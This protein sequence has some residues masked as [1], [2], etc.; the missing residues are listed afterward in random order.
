MRIKRYV[1]NNMQNAIAM[2]KAD[3][4][5]EAVILHTKRFKRGGIFGLF[6]RPKVEVLAAIEPGT[7]PST[8][9]ERELRRAQET[10]AAALDALQEEVRSL[11]SMIGPAAPAQTANAVVPRG[12]DLAW[13]R[14]IGQE[15]SETAA[16]RLLDDVAAAGT[17]EQLDDPVWVWEQLI[18][19]IGSE[20]ATTPPWQFERTPLV[21]PLIGPTGVGKTTTVAKLAANF[22]MLADKKVALVTADTYRVAAVQQLRT[23][24]DIIGIDLHVVYTPEELSDV[25]AE[26]TDH[27]LILIDTAGRSQNNAMHMAELRTFLS[28]LPDPEVHLVVSA[29]TRRSDLDEIVNRFSQIDFD[30][31]IVTKL[32]ETS[33]SGML[34]HL[35][36][37]TGKSLAYITHGQSVPD[38]IEVADGAEAA[39]R[40]MGGAP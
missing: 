29:T 26:L 39:R 7:Q 27:D 10:T 11:R 25:V 6:G 3:F 34:Y 9:Q 24:A 28:V 20:I 14:L 19:K 4:G 33:V 5:E 13:D 16:Q 32:D 15:L 35:A 31:I 21:V 17:G 18:A 40:I 37:Q 36:G 23:Y 1:A 8:K 30:R 38:D 22:K 12:L 2:V